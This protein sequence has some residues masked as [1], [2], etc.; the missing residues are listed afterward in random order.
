[1]NN[2]KYK[3]GF[4]WRLSLTNILIIFN[5][6]LFIVFHIIDS[7]F[8]E[9][10][11][12]KIAIVSSDILGG[13]RIWSLLTSMFAHESGFHLFVNM[14]SLYFLG[15]LSE[16]IIG[17]KR[18]VWL[19]LLAGLIGSVSFVLFAKI[20]TL[21]SRGDFLFGSIDIPALGASGAI[22]G[23]LGIL[24]VLIPRSKV[25]LIVGP[26]VLIIGQLVVR[27]YLPEGLIGTFDIIVSVLIFL[28]IFAMFSFNPRFRMIA[29]PV[30]MPLWIAPIIAIV[31][32]MIIS[33]YYPLPIGNT[34]H[35][36]GLVVGLIFGW[37]LRRKY[38][39]KVKIL[40]R[41]FK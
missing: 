12:S 10:F 23:L 32:L 38:K 22:F 34:A 3:K 4:F 21:F 28:M 19:Y 8:I 20:G 11:F 36:G 1:M 31:P 33:Y 14:F 37:Y 2:K 29:L 40:Q 27:N 25:F 30:G 41:Y 7:F 6:F 16:R 13:G 15:N 17:K 24:A 35:F 39:R 9:N 18:F 5:V 26:L